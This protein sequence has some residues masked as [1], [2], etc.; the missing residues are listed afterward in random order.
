MDRYY[1][2]ST[3]WRHT[4]GARI[5][6]IPLDAGFTCPN[7]DGTL[8]NTGCVFCNANGSGTGLGH[9]G[10]SLPEQWAYWQEFYAPRHKSGLY[11]AYLQAFSNT[12]GPPEKLEKVFS[13]LEG[14]P[15]LVGM[16]IGTRP[17]C[18]DAARLDCI[19]RVFDRIRAGIAARDP[20]HAGTRHSG[21]SAQ[22]WLELGLQSSNDAT[23]RRINRGHDFAA[24][25][26]AVYMARERGFE[27]CAHLMAGLPGETADDFLRTAADVAALPVTGIK[28][29]GL[30]VADRTEMARQWRQGMYTPM[31][32]EAYAEAVVRALPLFSANVVIHRLTGDAAGDELLSPAWCADKRSVI[33]RI[34]E[35]LQQHDVWQGQAFDASGGI[36]LHFSRE[37]ALPATLRGAWRKAMQEHWA[38]PADPVE[39]RL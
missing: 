14:L 36:P 22:V 2:L 28:L 27:V 35:L 8:S 10:L 31:E 21:Q 4:Y 11:I 39:K 30:Y 6:K 12:Y 17:D 9:K 34:H 7:R 5:Q 37:E 38:Q 29:H 13:C 23:L 15:G 19:A 1:R 24:F 25:A 18:V 32:R 16:S 20:A 3:Y 26:R 33:A